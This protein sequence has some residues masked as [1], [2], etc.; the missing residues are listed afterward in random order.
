M[1]RVVITLGLALAVAVA[2]GLWA[3][4]SRSQYMGLSERETA[5]ADKAEGRL[6][7]V[8]SDLRAATT[9]AADV[10]QEVQG[11]LEKEPVWA[12]GAVPP[13]VVSGL[14]KRGNCRKL[15]G[16]SAPADKP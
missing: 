10:R 16:V 6:A 9:K 5:R 7:R 4:D 15:E 1:I 2:G 8:Q 3:L 14:C 13:A 11:A 12:A